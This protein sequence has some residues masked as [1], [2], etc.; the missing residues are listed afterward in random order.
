VTEKK[1]CGLLGLWGLRVELTQVSAVAT[2][3]H[4]EIQSLPSDL[5]HPPPSIVFL[6]FFKKIIRGS[7]G[8]RGSKRNKVEWEKENE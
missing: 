4:G 7:L 2:G 3:V 8:S 1:R 6:N 5:I